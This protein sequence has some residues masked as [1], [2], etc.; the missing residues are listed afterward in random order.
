MKKC[1]LHIHSEY[2]DSDSKIED[3]FKLAKENDISC[4]AITDHDTIDGLGE[5]KKFSEI[6][7][8]ELINGIE[9]S[10]QKQN[11]EVHILGYFIDAES[12]KLKNALS[13]IKDLRKERLI[14]MV[15][16]LNSLGLKID[17]EEVALKLYDKIPT[18][19]HLALFLMEKGFVKNIKEAFLKYL[20]YGRPA[21]VA[22]FKYSP[23]EAISLIKECGGL[24]ILAHPHLLP[25]Q[26]LIE[27][28]ILYGLDG[29]EVVYPN[30]GKNQVIYENIVDKFSL[31]KSG[32]SDHHGSYK[33]FT[34]IGE[35]FIPYEWVEKMKKRYG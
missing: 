5:A 19:L 3:I 30:S 14:M 17:K 16:K 27:E 11:I 28:C 2:S 20:S 18:R 1:D 7:N 25:D 35:V 12:P 24:A 22:R 10:A 21:Y 8:I 31:L 6:F 33:D 4:V 34:K 26:S 29:L 32:G 23:K 9:I 15:E 13:N